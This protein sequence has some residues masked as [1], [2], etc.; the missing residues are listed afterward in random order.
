MHLLVF[1]LWVLGFVMLS[2]CALRAVRFAAVEHLAFVQSVDF[3]SVSAIPPLLYL[4]TA[5]IK[6]ILEGRKRG[7]FEAV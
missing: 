4:L 2:Q 6:W 3:V 7:Y 1:Y 5:L